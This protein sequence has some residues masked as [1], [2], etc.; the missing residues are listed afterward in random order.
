MKTITMRFPG[1]RPKAL[2]LSY[3]DGVEQDIRLMS[4]MDAHGIKGTFNLNSGLLKSE[5]TSYPAGKT[6]RQLTVAQARKVY[7]HAGHEVAVHGVTHPSL[8]QLPLPAAL[9]EVLED[10]RRLEDMF[11]TVVR[12]MAYPYGT[13][14]DALIEGLRAV[15]IAYAR[16]T[17]CREDFAIPD[18]WLRLKATCHHCHPRLT[19]LTDRF[20]NGD[21]RGNPWLFY[22]WGH[23]YE[24]EDNDNWAVIERFCETVGG[25]E[26]VWYATNLEIYDYVEAYRRLQFG[27]DGRLVY[28]PSAVSVWVNADGHVFEVK[29]GETCDV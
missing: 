15:G 1:G 25:R 4:I 12:G 17:A 11:G 27:A 8:G 10:R 14:N 28:N 21:Q 26:D 16:T 18:D 24:F 6:H 9:Q 20:L 19:E 22:L 7:A 23:S 13:Y 2:T 29:A 5:E 3:D